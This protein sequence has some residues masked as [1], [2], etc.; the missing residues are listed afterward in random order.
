MLS[1]STCLNASFGIGHK[2]PSRTDFTDR[3][4]GSPKAE[5][6][7][8]YEL[9]VT[10]NHKKYIA[11]LNLYYMDYTNQLVLTGAVNDV[12]TPLRTNVEQSYRAG[13]EANLTYHLMPNLDIHGNF[14]ISRN[15]ISKMV[16]ETTDYADYSVLKDTL[17]NVPI[18]YS[19]NAVAALQINW[20]PAKNWQVNW[21]H[22]FVGKQYLDNTG[23]ADK[24]LN[25]YYFSELW[26]SKAWNFKNAT[27]TLKIQLLN[28][29]NNLYNNNGYSW[30]YL[31]GKNNLTRE[32]F[33]FPSA[34]RNALVGLNISF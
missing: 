16:T 32:V 6:M 10:K 25:A 12:G 34:P 9:G 28:I 15:R 11:I 29:F 23:E 33:Y 26:V 24:M 13:I 27:I 5:A 18:S 31:Y 22:K 14:A 30:E 21:N 7:I 8:D 1:P 17:N 3:L 2:E 20:K 19:P 4:Y